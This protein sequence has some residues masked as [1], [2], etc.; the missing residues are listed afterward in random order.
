MVAKPIIMHIAQF[1]KRM[2]RFLL[3]ERDAFPDTYAGELNYQCGRIIM[4]ASL[5]CIV[6]WLSYVDVDRQLFPQEPLIVWLRYGLTAV[7]LAVFLLQFIP[8]CKRHSMLLLAALGFYLE[9]ATGVIT[10]LSKADPVYLGG[11]LFVLMIPLVAPVGRVLL[12]GMIALSLALF[13]TVGLSRGM[14][15]STLRD[16]YKLNDLIVTF[17][18]SLVFIYILDRLR[19]ASW[20]KSMQIEQQRARIQF[21]KE[22]VESVVA[23]SRN[24][25]AHV[26]RAA[27]I[28]GDFSSEVTGIIDTQS[29]L[30]SRSREIGAR[31]IESFRVLTEETGREIESS[32]VI[33]DLTKRLRGDL[34]TTAEA[35]RDASADAQK[36]EALSDDC[37]R[38]LQDARGTIERLRDESKMIEE[39]SQTINEISDQT[40]LL[41]L[42]ASIESARA[43]EHGRGFAVVAD[44]ISKLAD[45]SQSS[46]KEISGIIGRSVERIL[47]AAVQIDDASRALADIIGFLEA[48]RG[49]LL[50]FQELVRAQDGDFQT[51]I[52]H[53]ENLLRYT[54]SITG[55]TARNTEAVA[56]SQEALERIEGFYAEL[57]RMANTLRQLSGDLAG[58]VG[59]LHATLD[60]T[61][62][63]DGAP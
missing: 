12:W 40:N 60:E 18:F 17:V 6:A 23:E 62:K 51:V 33:G 59:N 32:R 44:E 28:L 57:T 27:A 46:A 35:G 7:S 20:R 2:Q 52:G 9:A 24:V 50:R 25:A 10:G 29:A 11:Y 56:S 3:W 48:N 8:F 38:K 53:L 55:L 34:Q 47:S 42:N 58:H 41:S 54:E 22:R 39:I 14:E 45:K 19:K 21:D 30:F 26:R 4:P 61:L 1:F 49:F 16:Q 31:L 15:F 13:F 5:I 37:T 36:I 43:G 63:P